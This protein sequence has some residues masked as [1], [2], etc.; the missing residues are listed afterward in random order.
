MQMIKVQKNG[1]GH[2]VMIPVF[3]MQVLH[4]QRGDVL[5][6]SVVGDKV[7][8]EVLLKHTIPVAPRGEPKHRGTSNAEA[9]R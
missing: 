2:S 3:V 7:Q 9:K 6:V 4:L 1:N 5:G 8:Y